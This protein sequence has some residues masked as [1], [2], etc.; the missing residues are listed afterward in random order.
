MKLD[1]NVFLA[2]G[3]LGIICGGVSMLLTSGK[4]FVYIYNTKRIDLVIINNY[5][6][7]GIVTAISYVIIITLIAFLMVTSIL[8]FT[9]SQ[10]TTKEV[11]HDHTKRQRTGL[12]A[13]NRKKH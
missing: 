10:S 7:G 6:I 1:K 3:F 13:Q 9:E 4:I 2:S 8:H 11:N 5:M 12:S